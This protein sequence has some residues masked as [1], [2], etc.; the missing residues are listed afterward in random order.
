MRLLRCPTCRTE[1]PAPQAHCGA[2]LGEVLLPVPA[3]R[4][5]VPY[6]QPGARPHRARRQPT[7]PL[8]TL[9]RT[10]RT[11]SLT[12]WGYPGLRLPLQVA[13]LLS[14]KPGSGKSTA[15]TVMALSLA[16]RGVRVLWISPEEGRG[17]T[18]AR[19]FG[20]AHRWLSS[21]TLPLGSPLISDSRGL[22]EVDAELRAFEDAGGQVIFI[23]S[24]TTLGA[25]DQWWEDLTNSPMGVVGIAH[26]N[27][28][29]SPF[30]GHRIAHDPDIHLSVTDFTLA[31]EKSRWFEEDAPRSWSVDAPER[32]EDA[33]PTLIPFPGGP[34]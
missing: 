17:D 28:R 13:M 24:I 34:S 19:R 26:Q 18:T 25:S 32:D 22:A 2:C 30:G 5:G 6:G 3:S 21:P 10:H 23:D 20:M 9:L 7:I 16:L 12:C 27:S 33:A 31:V 14:G 1:W 15:A 29:G 4:D 8:Q 11:P